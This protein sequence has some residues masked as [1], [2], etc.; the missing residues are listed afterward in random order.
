MHL[1]HFILLVLLGLLA[2]STPAVAGQMVGM[3]AGNVGQDLDRTVGNDLEA[4]QAF[5]EDL[6]LTYE[7]RNAVK[8]LQS[9]LKSSQKKLM[10]KHPRLRLSLRELGEEAVKFD[11]RLDTVIE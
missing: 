1:L 4:G 9:R 11:A 8:L 7:L 3:A 2:P 10:M 6:L 5:S